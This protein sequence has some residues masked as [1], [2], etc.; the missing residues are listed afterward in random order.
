MPRKAKKGSPRYYF[1]EG[2]EQGIIDYNNAQDWREKNAIYNEH[3]RQPFEKLCENIIHTFK[4]Y[5]FDVPSED[6]KHEVI[7][8]MITRL[9]KYKQG[10]GKAFSYFSVVVKN[11][12][13]CHNNANYKKMKTHTDVVDLKHKD[14]KKVTYESKETQTEDHSMFY[15]GIIDY[16]ETNIPKVFKK[17][18]DID[19]AHSIVDLMTRVDSIEIF[20]KKALYILLREISGAQT[21]HITKVLNVM[22]TH[23]KSL[24]TQWQ[25]E[26]YIKISGNT[27]PKG[28]LKTF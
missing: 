22:R 27:R 9:D 19:I 10:K 6:V 23:Y 15:K 18:R 16:W 20:N 2:T 5:H 1:H 21:Q 17:K 8:F 11:W 12:L 4:F 7:S 26:G 14:A 24:D 25:K 13:I 28:S 3:L